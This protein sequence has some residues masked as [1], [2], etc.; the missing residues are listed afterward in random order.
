MVSVNKKK[1]RRG[2]GVDYEGGE[3]VVAEEGVDHCHH[4]EG[5]EG[6]LEVVVE[7][8]KEEVLE[9]VILLV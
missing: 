2:E 5:G 9:V 8:D 6:H 7:V 4:H 1:R 3:V